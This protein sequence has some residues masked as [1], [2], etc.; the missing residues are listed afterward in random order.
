MNFPKLYIIATTAGI[1]GA[2]GGSL[3]GGFI[4]ASRCH[5]GLECLGTAFLGVGLGSVLAEASF[6]S[7]AVHIGN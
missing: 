6:M 4:A 1:I 2:I 7:F 5:G 3:A